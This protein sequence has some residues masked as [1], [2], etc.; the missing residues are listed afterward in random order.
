[1]ST[2]DKVFELLNKKGLQQK[3]LTDYLGIDKGVAS[4]WKS[5]KS[6]SYQKYLGQIAEFLGVRLSEI[7]DVNYDEQ[8]NS[9]PADNSRSALIRMVEKL[10]DT[11][12]E[13]AA[14][15]L[16]AVYPNTLDD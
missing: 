14:A 10:P 1:M 2:I 11:E 7:V 9:T 13:R 12:L 3:D 16:S 8:K 15:I 5:G 4:Q 6:K